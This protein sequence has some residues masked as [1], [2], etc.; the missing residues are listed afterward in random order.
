M[1]TL[2]TVPPRF[3]ASKL[4]IPEL[5]AEFAPRPRLRQLLDRAAADQVIVLSAP[6][7]SGKTLLVA[8]WVRSGDGP[9]TA[10]LSLDVDDNDPHRLRAAVVAALLAVPSV[11][12]DHRLQRLLTD[13]TKEHDG[14]GDRDGDVVET[15]AAALDVLDPPVRLVLDDVHALIGTQVLRDLGRLVRRRPAGV[16]LVLVSRIDPPISVPRL[17]LEGRLHELRVDVLR[18]TLDDTAALLH[19][20]DLQLIPAQVARLY[21]RTDG[22]GAGLRL[23]ALALRRT[24]D[25]DGFLA[26]FS[27]DERSVADYLTGEIVAGLS[28]DIRDLLRSV[29]LCSPLPGALAAE[30]SGRPDAA[31]L[32][33]QLGKETALVER[34]APGSYRI[35][36]LLRSYLSAELARH[37][38]A[39]YRDLESTVA[40]WW[41]AAGQPVHALRH[42]ERAGDSALITD[43]VHGS[44]MS[45]LLGGDLGPL[46]RA[47]AAVGPAARTTDPWL[48]LTAAISHLESR[49]LP[50]ATAALG[51]ARRAWP[52]EPDAGLQALLASAELL[53]RAEGLDGEPIAGA[54]D[55]AV[56]SGSRPADLADAG[57]AQPEVQALLHASRGVA[58]YTT[59]GGADLDLARTEF[60]RALELARVHD[61][62]YLEVQCLWMLATLAALHGDLRGMTA[63]ADQAVAA[64]AR[65][66]RHPSA[67]SA[68]PAGML[69]YADLLRGEPAAAAARCEEALGVGDPLPV[70]AAQLL[71]AVHGAALAD[72]GQRAAGLA[73]LRAARAEFGHGVV[74]P[75]MAAALA[76]LEHR[77]ALLN[78]NLPAAAQAAEWLTARTGPTAETLLLEAWT[79]AAAGRHAAAEIIA[80]PVFEPDMPV[81]LP[82]TRVEAL[83]LHA[84]AALHA[85]DQTTG[86][87]ALQ[88]ALAQAEI[89]G[90]AWPLALAG[91]RT[92]ELL[93]TRAA[94]NG[95]GPFADRVAAARAAVVAD[96]AVPLSD[97]ERDVLE[98]LPSLLTSRQIAEEFTVSVNTVKT[99]V[100]AIYAKLGVSSRSDAVARAKDAGLLP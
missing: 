68:G 99:H 93:V 23:A 25:P 46:R 36:P 76:L 78:G 97:R 27:G 11:A 40:R 28:A 19:A 80:A 4:L 62:G 54:A 10:W 44:G 57:P 47:L 43:V 12:A 14:D 6:G 53:A 41:L 33:D 49:D 50:A 45:L 30:L 77:V 61:L 26:A 5:P 66:G 31:A 84:E 8:D 2:P 22:W 55:D 56:R 13:V 100:R 37:R 39:T 70:E 34:T 92:Q 32:L 58:E 85:G 86:R 75:A 63:A 24:D 15:L 83:L 89:L 72:R 21:T 38:P 20:A 73:E 90:V 88:A 98:L 87:A 74:P 52:V 35:Q 3:P 17:R 91:P 59:P 16:R 7:G 94:G 81:L 69:A 79:Q 18:F 95:L 51:D 48:A 1:A 71:H 29:S 65:R 64:A 60:D 9:E 42:A 67:W 82:H 96:P